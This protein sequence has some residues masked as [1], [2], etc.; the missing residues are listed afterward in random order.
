MILDGVW[1]CLCVRK[2]CQCP[3]MSSM[4]CVRISAPRACVLM[5]AVK[6]YGCEPTTPRCVCLCLFVFV[7][8]VFV[9][10]AC[11]CVHVSLYFEIERLTS[12]WCTS[13]CLR[14]GSLVVVSELASERVRER[15][16][17]RER[18]RERETERQKER[19]CCVC[20]RCVYVCIVCLRVYVC[21]CVCQCVCMHACMRVSSVQVHVCFA[22]VPCVFVN[23]CVCVRIFLCACMKGGN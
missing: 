10:F 15:A 23:V 22:N 13:T 16:S 12:A 1:W 2:L 19:V 11:E 14:L 3:Y 6:A 9:C 8:C 7:L 18:A 5:V 21:V 20:D 17:Q 4:L